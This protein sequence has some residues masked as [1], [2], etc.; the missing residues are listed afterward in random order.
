MRQLDLDAKHPYPVTSNQL[1]H[2]VALVEASP[3]YLTARMGLVESRLV[4]E[5]EVVLTTNPSA[6][7]KRLESVPG[8]ADTR[9]WLR[10]YQVMLRHAQLSPEAQAKVETAILPS[11][12]E[13]LQLWKGRLKHLKGDLAGRAAPPTI[14]RRPRLSNR[15]LR[16]M[17]D[18][19]MKAKNPKIVKKAK[20]I[21]EA[22]LTARRTQ[23]TG[24]D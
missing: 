20:E 7:V 2:V 10:P 4:G 1:S 24:S 18:E 13:V 9:L 6:Q 22:T 8:L 19:V 12:P 15:R 3:A 11:G 23:V 5:Q 17:H 21:Y 16:E 14:I